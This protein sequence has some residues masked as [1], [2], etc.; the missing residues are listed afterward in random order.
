M[1]IYQDSWGIETAGWSIDQS[2]ECVTLCP[3]D[4]EAA[5][6][7]SCHRKRSGMVTIEDLR[8]F[9]RQRFPDSDFSSVQRCG[10]FDSVVAEFSAEGI[11]WRYWWLGHGGTHLF[12]T[13]NCDEQSKDHHNAVVDWMLSSLG[14]IGTRSLGENGADQ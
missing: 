11:Y 6:Q 5:L 8:T 4:V 1:R 13:Y 12:V 2:P 7:I 3:A 9:A 10:D 14:A